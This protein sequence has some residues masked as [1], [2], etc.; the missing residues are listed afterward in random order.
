MTNPFPVASD[1]KSVAGDPLPS[2][3]TE[4][5]RYRAVSR[6]AVASVVLG[7]LSLLT[8]FGWLFALIP[9]GGLI[10][11]W[12]ARR[13]ILDNPEELTGLGLA[14]GGIAICLAFGGMGLGWL[15]YNYFEPVP[16]GYQLVQ[17]EEFQPDRNVPGQVIPPGIYELQDKK[18]FVRGY[19]APSRRMLNLKEF[20]LCPALPDC[21]FC[22]PNP[23]KT[24]MILVKLTGDLRTDFT[25][26][27]VRVGGRL[28]VDPD[29]PNGIPYTIEADYLR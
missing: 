12:A 15:I 14:H 19:M 2:P 16:F 29:S 28:K 20:I 9:L 10:L 26:R 18:V 3:A 5:L 22:I 25:T 7:G 11:G 27:M 8:L 21:S 23:Q 13:I 24:E 6:M 4:P 17:Y 1:S